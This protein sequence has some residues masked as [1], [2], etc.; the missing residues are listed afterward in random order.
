MSTES[1]LSVCF[2]NSPLGH[3]YVI[4]LKSKDEVC[5]HALTLLQS[6]SL[7]CFLPAELNEN[8]DILS[9]DLAGCIPLSE[10]KGKDKSYV[11]QH[12]RQLLSSFLYS[13]IQSVDHAM[14]PGGICFLE[15][16]LFYDRKKQK[17]VA[18]Y[19]PL[20]S[21]LNSAPFLSSIDESGLDD[22]LHY[23]Y[24]QNWISTKA[25][26]H[27]YEYFRNDDDSSALHYITSGLWDDSRTLLVRLRSILICW[28]IL[29]VSDISLSPRIKRHFSCSILS[30]LPDMLFFAGTVSLLI[31]LFIRIRN[32]TKDKKLFSEKKNRRRRNRN[33]RILFP[34][35]ESSE[36]N[37]D[38][39]FE[40]HQ[41]PVQLIRIDNRTSNSVPATRLTI[42]TN[43]CTVGSDSDCCALS[44][45]HSSLALKHAVFGHDE[46][47]FYVEALQNS[48][49][50]FRNKQRIKPEER[51]YLKEGDLVGLGDL[52]FE[53]HFIHDQDTGQRS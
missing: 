24:E 36:Q 4:H 41:D 53:V 40:F 42:W 31:M 34:S 25:M 52:E 18:V 8:E 44:I 12:H 28:T 1:N 48:K 51:S 49:G 47:G 16:Q 37:T 6:D 26:D 3:R 21:R 46:Y 22:L 32:D 38:L 39:S 20:N 5:L 19:L 43:T 2:E 35:S 10:L 11:K 50:T 15:D 27:L 33:T 45:D 7:P 30:V 9:I 17:L 29:L 23:A 13:L 14:D